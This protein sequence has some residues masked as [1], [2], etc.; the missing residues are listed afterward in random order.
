MFLWLLSLHKQRS[1]LQQ[2]KADQVTRPPKGAESSALALKFFACLLANKST[3]F[4]PYGRE[5]L[6]FACAKKSN[7]KKAH[8]VLAPSA[9]RRSGSASP[10]EIFVRDIHVPYKNVAHPCAPPCGLYLS[11]LPL[12]Y[13]APEKLKARAKAKRQAASGKRQ[14]E[15]MVEQ[16]SVAVWKLSQLGQCYRAQRAPTPTTR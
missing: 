2:P 9:P 7:Q 10:A 4:T 16:C 1:A 13:G 14:A 8:P 12:R 6:F 11:A 15:L 3:A 5:S